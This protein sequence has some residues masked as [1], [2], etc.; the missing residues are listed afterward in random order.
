M[1]T[2]HAALVA[3]RK[4]ATMSAVSILRRRHS[5]ADESAAPFEPVDWINV[6]AGTALVAGGLLLLGRQRRTGLA[7]AAAGSALV[8]LDHQDTL[9]AWW[10][11]LPA[12]VDRVQ[13]IVGQVQEKV[14]EITAHRDAIAD[15]IATAIESPDLQRRED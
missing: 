8:L 3:A 13:G 9:R 15:A 14:G 6:A 1:L 4:R 11:E 10:R 7:V 2:L 5:L 12:F